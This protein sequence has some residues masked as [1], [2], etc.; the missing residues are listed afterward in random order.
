MDGSLDAGLRL[1]LAGAVP[2]ANLA[3]QA[4]E[5]RGVRTTQVVL[6]LRV[7]DGAAFAQTILSLVRISC[8]RIVN[9]RPRVQP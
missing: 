3:R 5:A 6:A 4:L 9:T 1:I 8:S 7:A 2:N